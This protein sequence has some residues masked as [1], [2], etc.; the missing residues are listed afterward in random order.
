MRKLPNSEGTST[1]FDDGQTSS[2]LSQAK[3][4]VLAA[5]ALGLSPGSLA[6]DAKKY[7]DKLFD[8]TVR[9]AIEEEGFEWKKGE[10][11]TDFA[12]RQVEFIATSAKIEANGNP[13]KQKVLKKH[14]KRVI[15]YWKDECEM[16]HG[17]AVIFC[18]LY[19][20][21]GNYTGPKSEAD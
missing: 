2:T 13:V 17:K 7:P 21:N 20:A 10:K 16:L 4:D 9:V 3:A 18:V 12:L 8:R 5:F 6:D 1:V 11:A 15:G 19:D 14:E